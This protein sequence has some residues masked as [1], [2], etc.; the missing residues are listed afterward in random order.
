MLFALSTSLALLFTAP[1][2]AGALLEAE[3]ASASAPCDHDADRVILAKTKYGYTAEWTLNEDASLTAPFV[4]NDKAYTALVAWIHAHTK[5]TSAAGH[6]Q[7]DIGM[8]QQFL[9][10]IPLS[11]PGHKELQRSLDQ[12]KLIASGRAGKVH[13][14]NCQE[15]IPYREYLRV[16]NLEKYPQE[17]SA[18]YLRKDGQLKILGDFYWDPSAGE[19][20]PTGAGSS[21]TSDKELTKLQH[22][23]WVL[24]RHLHDHTYVF[25]KD[26]PDVGGNLNPSQPDIEY[27]I[28]DK[29]PGALI[30][31]GLE[32][33]EMT[34]E[35][36]A[37]LNAVDK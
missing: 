24:D 20:N 16:V 15:G 1:S 36:I 25:I 3:F 32:T 21:P 4:T 27:Y 10:E 13:A 7:H 26:A 23:G 22:E 18:L 14:I 34:R 2:R 6:Y 28:S 8:Y 5:L 30:S 33:I 17:F 35:D 31:N 12:L 29:L 37:A 11:D 9:T 19:N